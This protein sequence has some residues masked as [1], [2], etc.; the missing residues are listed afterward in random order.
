MKRSSHGSAGVLLVEA[1][2][3]VWYRCEGK[4]ISTEWPGA[5][6]SSEYCKETIVGKASA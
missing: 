6:K 5:E 2:T 4:T 1:W 3:G